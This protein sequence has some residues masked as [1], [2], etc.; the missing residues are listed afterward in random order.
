MTLAAARIVAVLVAAYVAALLP[1]EAAAQSCP[2]N[3][4]PYS[5]EET[6]TGTV[7][8]C[9]CISG[10]ALKEGTCQVQPAVAQPR[11]TGQNNELAKFCAVKARFDED[12]NAIAELGF[13]SNASRFEDFAAEA[14]NLR[15]D[16]VFQAADNLFNALFLEK[17]TEPAIEYAKSLNPW[18]VNT[19]IKE[20][21]KAATAAGGGSTE[22]IEKALRALASVRNKPAI[23]PY[24]K[25]VVTETAGKLLESVKDAELK[26]KTK[27]ESPEAPAFVGALI[28]VGKIATINPWA[29]LAISGAE[30]A[31][32][33]ALAYGVSQNV[34]RLA[35]LN[36]AQMRQLVLYRDRIEKD[37]SAM[38]AARRAWRH[39][40]GEAKEP[41][42]TLG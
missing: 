21:R 32:T 24:A 11:R 7:T 41:N 22:A 39:A 31:R 30:M 10:Y 3:S 23:A 16:F 27:H 1:V 26:I 12:R 17:A 25:N 37:I 33:A 38:R 34:D 40:T 8:H 18:S 14:T 19:R 6:A 29:G 4:E 2:A 13:A 28:L 5:T 42:C 9:Q 15:N 36:E 35:E 20:L